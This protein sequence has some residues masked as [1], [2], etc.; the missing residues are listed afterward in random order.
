[1]DTGAASARRTEGTRPGPRS[2]TRRTTAARRRTAGRRRPSRRAPCA[3][4][5]GASRT[6]YPLTVLQ[7]VEPDC[8]CDREAP[9]DAALVVP[10]QVEDVA[11][12]QLKLPVQAADHAV[13]EQHVEV[14][15]N[16]NPLAVRDEVDQP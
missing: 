7:R 15:R 11:V 3:A 4:P 2:R 1:M 10:G 6:P 5:R 12:A 13:V 14:V 16:R 8:Q 9:V